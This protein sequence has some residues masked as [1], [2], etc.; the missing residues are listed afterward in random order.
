MSFARLPWG[1]R[2]SLI[3]LTWLPVVYTFTN[4][5][6]LPFQIRGASMSPTFNP[7]TTTLA[8]DVVIVQKFNVK[9]PGTLAR[10]DIVVFHSPLD[11]ERLVTKRIVGIQGEAI[12]TKSPP[13][14]RPHANVPRNHLWV[15]GDNLFHSID[16]NTF[17]PISQALVVGK[18]IS[19]VWPLS[20]LGADLHQ[21]ACI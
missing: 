21:N 20:R 3:S 14:P 9:K 7:N 1:V 8:R 12:T 15:E 17:G 16:S 11:P 19:V 5:V 18:V 13:Y 10:G 2:T 4:H 6:Y